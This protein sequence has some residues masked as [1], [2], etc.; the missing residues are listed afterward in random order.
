MMLLQ[1]VCKL[2]SRSDFLETLEI[3]KVTCKWIV[4]INYSFS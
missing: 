1:L 2:L 4:C 3:E